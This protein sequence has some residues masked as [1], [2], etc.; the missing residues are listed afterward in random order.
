MRFWPEPAAILVDGLVPAGALGLDD[1]LDVP[2][3]GLPPSVAASVRSALA[4][5]LDVSVSLGAPG[6]RANERLT[7]VAPFSSHGLSFGGGVKPEVAIAG[8]ELV[9]ADPGR[10]ADRSARYGTISGSS[11]AAALAGGAAAVLAQIRP[12]L[13][14]AGVEGRS[15]R[16]GDTD[17]AQL[18][19][20]RREPVSSTRRQRVRP[21]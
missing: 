21:R 20:P 5:G 2:V 1:R 13:D 4:R 11:A 19:R 6:W 17:P 15:R 14:A 3:V 7:R 9:T 8:V 10:N 12:W 16:H 18:R